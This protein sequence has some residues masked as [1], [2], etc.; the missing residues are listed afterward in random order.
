[1]SALSNV[2]SS[3]GTS[4]PAG[5]SSTDLNDL[6]TREVRALEECS[7]FLAQIS[8]RTWFHFWSTKTSKRNSVHISPRDTHYSRQRRST[9]MPFNQQKFEKRSL[10]WGALV[11]FLQGLGC[12]IDAFSL[13]LFFKQANW[14]LSWPNWTF[15]PM[16]STLLSKVT[17]ERLRKRWKNTLEAPI[18][19]QRKAKRW[20]PVNGSFVWKW[21]KKAT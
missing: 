8:S 7:I 21:K 2:L 11:C 6:A 19:P 5:D 20:I 1:M 13:V 16:W 9:E 15:L 17:S 4:A 12:S 18:S 10:P 14:V 3:L